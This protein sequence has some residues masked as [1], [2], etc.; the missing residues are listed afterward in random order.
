MQDNA[1][2]KPQGGGIGNEGLANSYE[3]LMQK[4]GLAQHL[5]DQVLGSGPAPVATSAAQPQAA[6]PV[7]QAAAPVQQAAP[8][9]AQTQ[10]V[11]SPTMP[12][13]TQQQAPAAAQTQALQ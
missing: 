12:A 5:T 11:A 1:A 4:T 9:Q 13:M 10:Q 2:S 7:Q 8:A 6:A 3:S